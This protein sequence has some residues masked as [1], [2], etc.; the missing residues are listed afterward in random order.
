MFSSI[1]AAYTTDT[2]GAMLRRVLRTCREM[3]ADRGYVTTA[4]QDAASLDACRPVIEA[5]SP[6]RGSL[7]VVFCPEDKVGVKYT[8]A[9][10]ADAVERDG[11]DLLVVVSSDGPTPFCKR[12]C[13]ERY[14][15]CMQFFT[16]RQLLFNVTRFDMT[17]AHSLVPRDEAARL[18][19][20]LRVVKDTDWPR[21]LLRDPVVRYYDFRRGDIV[22]IERTHGGEPTTYYRIVV[23]E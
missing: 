8:R 13:D 20:E 6:T 12:E 1:L 3:V 5:R 7:R 9:L 14:A 21:I 17:P 15:D 23:R 22:R 2:R 16:Y 4:V 18:A 11:V 10:F 19:R